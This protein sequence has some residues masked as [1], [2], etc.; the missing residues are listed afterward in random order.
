METLK[1]MQEQKNLKVK[2]VDRDFTN[3]KEVD[4]NLSV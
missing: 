3:I 4:L 2:I 1:K